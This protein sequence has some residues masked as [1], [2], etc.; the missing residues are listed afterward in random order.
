M[1]TSS[2]RRSYFDIVWQQF[3]RNRSAYWSLWLLAPM[4]F[5]A[6]FAPLIASNQPLVFWDG[7]EMLFPWWRALFV[8]D[9]PVNFLFNMGL[10]AAAPWAAVML[11]MRRGWNE[12]GVS[13]RTR[14]VR[15]VLWFV[16]LT[17][18]VTAVFCVPQ[19][20]P[21]QRYATRSFATEQFD[22][23]TTKHGLYP[24]I[25]FGPIDLDLESVFKPPMYTKPADQRTRSN[26]A[27]PHLLGTD[28][29]GRDVLVQMLYGTRI[30]MTVGFLAVGLYVTIGCL[31]GALAGYFGGK[32][33]MFISRVIEVI[34]LFPAF[35]LIL[36]LVALIGPSIYIIMF[37]IGI[38]G[39]PTVARLIRAEVLR[40]RSLDYITAARACGASHARIIFR[41]LL[42][43]SIGPAMVS[44]PFGVA[45]AI[46]TEAG[47]SLL[48]FGVRPPTP[49]WGSLL[50]LGSANY[51]Y[52][53]L[54]VVPSLAIFAVVT[55]FNLVG[56]G[57][58]DAMDPKLRITA[59]DG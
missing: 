14:L 59:E 43:N 27:W 40:Q 48:G 54:V 52:W 4:C 44:A 34:M 22:E 36:T 16:L 41:H 17:L 35:F 39:W 24:P 11:V 26:D 13:G 28:D 47:L 6:I 5:A 2:G 49:S 50:R 55:L 45:G 51:N 57:L 10:L 20:R 46:M 1:T 58:R 30:S 12:R 33:D 29:M 53:W 19:I 23:P 37:V 21:T 38:T 18:A 25:P 56:G 8:I 42:P 32:F 15:G 7:Q 9:E 3:R 31:I